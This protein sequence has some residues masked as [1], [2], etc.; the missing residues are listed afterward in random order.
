MSKECPIR[1]TEEA[2]DTYLK[3]ITF[4]LERWTVSEVELFESLTNELLNNLKFNLKLC[5]ESKKSKLRKC[6]ISSQTSLV[7]RVKAKTVELITFVDNRSNHN[8]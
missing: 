4:I 5:P 3:T 7:Y 8:Y 2:S 1:W 6:V